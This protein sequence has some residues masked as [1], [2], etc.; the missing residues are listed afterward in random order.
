MASLQCVYLGWKRPA[1]E[2]GA[3]YL[4]R[5]W[6][7]AGLA[8][9]TN[10]TVVLPTQRAG[11]RLREILLSIAEAK[12]IGLFPPRIT[13]TG[14][15]PE[16]LYEQR[17]P[18]ATPLIQ[19]L[20]WTQALQ[21][22]P[23]RILAHIFPQAPTSEAD[24]RWLELGRMLQLQHLELAAH[25]LNFADV[26]TCGKTLTGFTDQRRWESLA[27]VQRR[28]LEIL[29]AHELWDRPT[30]RHYAIDHEEC[31]IDGDLV[32]LGT[33]DLSRTVQ[34][35]L[36]LIAEQVT[37]LV[38]ADAA[39][40]HRFDDYGC[41]RAEQWQNAFLD[42]KDH[43]IL[44]ADGP[45]NQADAVVYALESLEGK[46]APEDITIGIP[47]VSLVPHLENT[48]RRFRLTARWGPGRS[49]AGSRPVQWLYIVADYLRSE[50]YT[51]FAELMRHTDTDAYL[52]QA[53]HP[54]D[55]IRELDRFFHARLPDYLRAKADAES[56]PQ[57]VTLIQ[58]LLAPLQGPK[59]TPMAWGSV[60][61][62]VLLEL[63]A[64]QQLNAEHGSDRV[65]LHVCDQIQV[66]VERFSKIPETL[67]TPVS[68]STAI[69]MLLS[70]MDE[71]LPPVSDD[72]AIEMVG[73]LDL[74]LDDAKVAI[75]T[76]M[77]EGVVPR[78]VSSDVFLPN[79][80]R[81][82]LELD[83]NAV[84]YARDAYALQ[85][86]LQ[87]RMAVRFIVGR[88]QA[89]NDP[90]RPSR[91]LMA[92]PKDK[93]PERCRRLFRGV[94]DCAPIGFQSERETAAFEV[95]RPLP[96][97]APIDVLSVSDFSRF[98]ACPYRFYLSKVER[99]RRV[100]DR[101]AELDAPTFGDVAHQVVEVFGKQ[102]VRDSDDEDEIRGFLFQTLDAVVEERFG[103]QPRPTVQVQMAQLRQRLAAFARCQAEWRM[104][105]WRILHT[106]HTEEMGQFLVDDEPI[107][108]VGRIDRIDHRTRDGVE[109]YAVLDYKTGD[110]GDAPDKKH[111]ARTN[112]DDP[113][114]PQHW[115]DLQLPLYRH[116]LDSIDGMRDASLR[117]GYVLLPASP[118]DTRFALAPWTEEELMTA[119]E[120]ARAVVRRIREE[121]F[122]P[123]T[124]PFPYAQSDDFAAIVQHGVFGRRSFHEEVLGA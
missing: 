11:R 68:A 44:I 109:E 111:L 85:V 86:L 66:A 121:Q 34:G 89:T 115:R 15:L 10:V 122:W 106:E 4:L 2:L 100:E 80:L 102:L 22:V 27:E 55:G 46:Y 71:D 87:S 25:R 26:A 90:L 76:S 92:T 93:L 103:T 116:L 88:R 124:D 21:R 56:L 13:T 32:L 24:P 95:P 31:R 53:G 29:D 8:D 5:C 28:Y 6:Q 3:E 120:A 94:S 118:G 14:Q 35:M 20:A 74:P 101:L 37:A 99:L 18:L 77:N 123:P 107:R 113:I 63:Y 7:H 23:G 97:S 78:S 1:L 57:S 41:V 30:A 62:E 38:Y 91:L 112:R 42:V 96:L 114:A 83:D 84:R 81:Q 73:W 16:L 108:L 110:V 39:Q 9:L 58:Q 98:L 119:D 75:V 79:A 64:H 67:A 61:L 105:G 47:D 33:V 65:I 12:G 49:V 45:S 36:N 52:A 50:R 70:Q 40:A 17:K 72:N 48:L 51:C 43:Q 19:Q 117:L 104:A 60:I 82:A 54:R 59:Q 69:L